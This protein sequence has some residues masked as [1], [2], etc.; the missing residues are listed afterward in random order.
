MTD[1][2][3]AT[4]RPDRLT[5][6]AFAAVALIGGGNAIA[7]KQSVGDLAPFWSAGAGS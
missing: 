2:L 3:A 4:P 5:L 1:A 7:V 6:G